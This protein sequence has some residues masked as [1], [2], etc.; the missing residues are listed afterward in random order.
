MVNSCAF[1][2]LWVR[3]RVDL[4]VFALYHMP[5]HVTDLL[6]Y[7]EYCIAEVSHDYCVASNLNQLHDEAIVEY[8][9]LT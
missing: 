7:I 8:T 9:G 2:L 1:N 4:F 5:R 6:R 3:V